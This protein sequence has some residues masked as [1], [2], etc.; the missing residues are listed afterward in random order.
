[1]LLNKKNFVYVSLLLVLL[2]SSSFLYGQGMSHKPTMAKDG[3]DQSAVFPPM[4]EPGKKVPFGSGYYLIYG[5]TERPKLGSP[6]MKVEI[7]DAQGKKDTSF[8]V[9]ADTGMPSMKGAHE[10]GD[11][12]FALSKKGDYLLPIP[13]VM[14]GGWEVRFTV[15]KEGKVIFRGSYNFNV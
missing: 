13:V 11:K 1:M 7:F 14:P 15:L 12:P 10:T 4:A 5:F 6:I 3:G 8:E 9:K 2:L